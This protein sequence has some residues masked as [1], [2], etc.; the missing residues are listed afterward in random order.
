MINKKEMPRS[1]GRPKGSLNECTRRL[2]RIR[3]ENIVGIYQDYIEMARNHPNEDVRLDCSKFLVDRQVPKV[4]PVPHRTYIDLPLLPMDTM[5][6]IKKNES[7]ILENISKGSI[8]LEEGKELFD[9][10]EQGRKSWECTEGIKIHSEIKQ[11][12][13]EVMGKK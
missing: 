2:M 9:I 12:W 6:N 13:E 10:T 11:M 7:I 4:S 8:S 1:P 5:E 3:E